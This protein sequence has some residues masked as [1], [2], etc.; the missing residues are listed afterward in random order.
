MTKNCGF[1]RNR[2]RWHYLDRYDRIC[3]RCG[4]CQYFIV[5]P[6]TDFWSTTDYASLMTNVH[7]WTEHDRQ[8]NE[9]RTRAIDHLHGVKIQ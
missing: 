8:D 2:H 5:T 4:E 6:M 9:S 3:E 1:L 7:E